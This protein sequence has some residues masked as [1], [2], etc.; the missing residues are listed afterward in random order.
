[1]LALFLK[2]FPHY[3]RV[4]VCLHRQIPWKYRRIKTK[5]TS[6]LK[7]LF[8]ISTSWQQKVKH[9]L[10][11]H[12]ITVFCIFACPN[13]LGFPH[14]PFPPTHPPE[15]KKNPLKRTNTAGG[16]LTEK[17][18]TYIKSTLIPQ[19]ISLANSRSDFTANSIMIC[20]LIY[21][22]STGLNMKALHLPAASVYTI[23]WSSLQFQIPHLTRMI[24]L[25]TLNSSG[26][27]QTSEFCH[28]HAAG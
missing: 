13:S 5:N 20:C 24:Y 2:M 25:P 6:Q 14:N 11:E 22:I 1:M 3:P 8:H 28:T 27:W 16:N 26:K 18:H 7:G 23:N 12:K 10:N 21:I 19:K 9:C 17:E 15:K 4:C